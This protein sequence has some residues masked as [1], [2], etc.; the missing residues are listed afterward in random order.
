MNYTEL[1]NDLADAATA[2]KSEKGG[3][4]DLPIDARDVEGSN[5]F[6]FFFKPELMEKT[7]RL[8]EIARFIFEKVEEFGLN[9]ESGFVVSGGYLAEHDVMSRHYGVIDA[10][11]RD[12]N[13]I[14]TA[15]MWEVFEKEFGVINRDDALLTGA[16]SYLSGHRELD[17]EGLARRWLAG[18]YRKLGGGTYCQYLEDEGAYLINGFYPRLLEH[19]TRPGA[20]I[21]CFILR[22]ETG[23]KKAR[24][25]FAGATAPDQAIEGS[26]RNGLLRRKEEFGIPEISPNLNGVH[27]SAGPLEGV[28]EIMRFSTK[29]VELEELVFGNMLLKAFERRVV[30]SMLAN[31]TVAAD[32]GIISYFD[33]T[34]ELDSREAIE[35]LRAVRA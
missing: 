6:L 10:G 5:Q 14:L 31:E 29:Y 8:P 20:C 12:P 1:I 32:Q 27:L 3:Y 28:V 17:A 13:A 15:S 23:W 34:E 22:G 25:E 7:E 2:A 11:A 21:A 35:A 26:I 33:L 4:I 16:I 9:C 19:F 18:G 30:D 24:G